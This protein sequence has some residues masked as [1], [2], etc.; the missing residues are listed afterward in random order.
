MIQITDTVQFE[1]GL[2]SEQTDEFKQ[3]YGENVASQITDLLPIE[4]RDKYNRPYL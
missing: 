3:W 4:A 1:N 2:L